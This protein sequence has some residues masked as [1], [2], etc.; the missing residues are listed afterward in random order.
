MIS[1]LAY[2]EWDIFAD[3]ETQ[4]ATDKSRIPK[5]RFVRAFESFLLS[6]DIF[7]NSFNFGLTYFL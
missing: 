5:K 1:R 4:W 7:F 6:F 2:N 3:F